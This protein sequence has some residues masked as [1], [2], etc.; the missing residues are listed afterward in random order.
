MGGIAVRTKCNHV[1][2]KSSELL[3][4]DMILNPSHIGPSA[5]HCNLEVLVKMKSISLN[6]TQCF[7][8][9]ENHHW[10][11]LGVGF[12]MQETHPFHEMLHEIVSNS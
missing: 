6:G 11:L 1:E 8:E 5:S 12:L 3:S 2:E 4:E 9:I 7:E 10:T